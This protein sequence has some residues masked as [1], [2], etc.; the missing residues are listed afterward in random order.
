MKKRWGS[1]LAGAVIVALVLLALAGGCG[2]SQKDQARQLVDEALRDMENASTV[3]ADLYALNGKIT[4]LGERF[5]NL[6]DTISEGK[7][8][9]RLVSEDID[10][11]EG[12]LVGVRGIFAEAAALENAGDYAAYAAMAEDAVQMQLNAMQTNRLLV[13]TLADLL[14]VVDKAENESQLQYY[15]DELERLS[16]QL[17]EEFTRAADLARQADAFFKEKKL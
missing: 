5:N 16:R 12:D 10:K 8:L 17:D 15:V 2:N 4:G 3:L 11:L 13:S 14:S 9:V 6:E 7:S 1:R